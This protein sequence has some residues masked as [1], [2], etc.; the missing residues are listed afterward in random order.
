MKNS[1][2]SEQ[3]SMLIALFVL[4]ALGFALPLVVTFVFL[5]IDHPDEIYQTLAQARRLTTGYGF[6]PWEYATEYAP[7]RCQACSRG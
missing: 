2:A 3:R 1:Q 7:G 6:V 4:L 5:N